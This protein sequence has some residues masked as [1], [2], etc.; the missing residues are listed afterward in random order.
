MTCDRWDIGQKTVKSKGCGW[1]WMV[2]GSTD[3]VIF[4]VLP[5]Y[6][7]IS[8][9]NGTPF[10]TGQSHC[11]S[12]HRPG[13]KGMATQDTFHATSDCAEGPRPP[14]HPEPSRAIQSQEPPK[15][16]EPQRVC[17]KS[18]HS[19]KAPSA[20]SAWTGHRQGITGLLGSTVA[21]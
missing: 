8:Q 6:C 14:S 13:G 17:M 2:V 19:E 1:L 20:W 16:G 18:E 21:S 7:D 9:K 10:S 4:G 15:P 3:L 12:V 11:D 5:Q